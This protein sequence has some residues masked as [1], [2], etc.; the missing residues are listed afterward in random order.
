MIIKL[1]LEGDLFESIEALVKNGKY[2]DLHQFIKIAIKNQIQEES[3]GISSKP[4]T[5]PS[6]L[7]EEIP[8]TL[9]EKQDVIVKHLWEFNPQETR[10]KPKIEDMICPFYTR[11]FPA[12]VIIHKLA[13]MLSPQ[14]PWIEIREIQDEAFI[15]AEKVSTKLRDIEDTNQIP[16]NKKLSTGLP[17]PKT[18]FSGLK[19]AKR[20]K[21]EN[22]YQS[23]KTRFKEQFVGKKK[24]KEPYFEGACF[25]MGLIAV[26]FDDDTCFV[27]LTEQG[28]N[29]ALLDNPIL[30][31]KSYEHSFSDDEVEFIFDNIYPKFESENK[32]IYEIIKALS[33]KKLKSDDINEIFQKEN[34]KDFRA[35]RVSTMGKLSELRIV[36]WKINKE[37]KSI[38]SL[39]EDNPGLLNRI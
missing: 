12:K 37:G 21:K 17:M 16:R 9:E 8:E 35:E 1:D 27:S 23:S 31:T 18:E 33:V 4:E 24:T 6:I 5:P 19:G 38:Y 29:F 7:T 26:K 14:K 2:S 28:K 39:N 30:D 10:Y 32:I 13:S 11:F 3:T 34:R 20:R 36:N 25:S 22:K 15:F